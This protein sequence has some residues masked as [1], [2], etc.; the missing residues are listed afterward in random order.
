M[1]QVF[2]SKIHVSRLFYKIGYV[3]SN[4]HLYSRT[5]FSKKV[6]MTY[7]LLEMSGTKTYRGSVVGGRGVER[8]EP[9]LHRL[10]FTLRN[11]E[12]RFLIG[13]GIGLIVRTVDVPGF[14]FSLSTE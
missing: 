1:I 3:Q 6:T 2:D 10:C 4:G 5:Y 7:F 11:L 8:I 12:V 13:V 9:R 14:R